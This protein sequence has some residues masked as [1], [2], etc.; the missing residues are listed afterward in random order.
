MVF[1]AGGGVYLGQA[2]VENFCVAA[3]RDENVGGLDVAMNDALAVGGVESV[4]DVDG[5][6]EENFHVHGAAGDG[7]LECLAVEKFHG[8]EGLSL[9]SPIS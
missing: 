2:E 1:A 9:A 5:E 3:L 8:D 4:G 6:S 7:V